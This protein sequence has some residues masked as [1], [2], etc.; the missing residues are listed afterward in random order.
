MKSKSGYTLI[1]GLISMLIIGAISITTI[2]F[3]SGYF[4]NT[5]N[6][7]MQ[8]KSVIENINTL[9]KVK[10]EVAT[11]SQLYAFSQ[12]HDIRIVAVG[13]GEVEFSTDGEMTVITDEKYGFSQKVLSNKAM[14]FRIEIGGDIPNT[15][16]I[17]IIK[18]EGLM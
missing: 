1:E 6:R 17:T 7:D 10:V 18:L 16:L 5:F 3:A 9:E 4:K 11:P 2:G 12:A 8:L 14:L 15:K 13:I